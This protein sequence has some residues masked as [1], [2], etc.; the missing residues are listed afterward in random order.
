MRG[1]DRYHQKE[2]MEDD[3][4]QRIDMPVRRYIKRPRPVEVHL[5]IPIMELIAYKAGLTGRA[6]QWSVLN[7][8]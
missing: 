7:A 8:D 6:V 2:R 4:I 3:I 1:N 5:R